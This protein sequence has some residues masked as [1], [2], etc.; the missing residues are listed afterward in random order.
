MNKFVSSIAVVLLFS[1]LSAWAQLDMTPRTVHED[2][3]EVDVPDQGHDAVEVMGHELEP[4]IG[5]FVA[6]DDVNVRGGPGTNFKR[7][8]GLK[9]GLRVRAIGNSKDGK[10]IAV[11]QD[12]ETLGFV[13][14]K[15]LKPVIDGTLGE[16]FFGSYMHQTKQ[17]GIA[18]DYRFRF[19]GKVKVEGDSFSTSDY[20]VRFRCASQQGARIFYAHMFLTEA[21]VKS[22][23]GQHLI[24]L[25]TRSIGD[26]MDEYLSSRFLYN[27]KTGKMKFN[28]HSLPRFATP[29]KPQEF[30][31][32]NIKDALVQA[33]ESCIDSWTSDAWEALLQSDDKSDVAPEGD[34]VQ[35]EAQGDHLG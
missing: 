2:E 16:Q 6:T 30:Q 31:T 24:G 33:L 20:E 10:W 29:P 3:A 18:C 35:D 21:P 15:I 19:D 22:S 11:S 12:G 13:F 23:S 4:L 28:G 27:P 8:D 34:D 32:K 14:A 17:G 25:D 26:G 9:G 7:I 1:P 5:V